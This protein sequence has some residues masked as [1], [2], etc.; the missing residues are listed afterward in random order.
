MRYET[1]YKLIESKVFDKLSI[2]ELL[3]QF[4]V[5]HDVFRRWI[6]RQRLELYDATEG[7]IEEIHNL[8]LS[9]SEA[10]TKYALTSRDVHRI[11][12]VGQPKQAKISKKE[13]AQYH[14]KGY[15]SEEIASILEC[16]PTRINQIK[17]ELNIHTTRKKRRVLSD[18]DRKAIKE[19]AKSKSQ[20]DVAIEFNVSAQT[21]SNIV[22][23]R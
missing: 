20:K 18:Q 8:A 9:P 21:V 1:L 4:Q 15:S 10:R 16:T 17:R 19:A 3:I 11:Y 23:G 14:E 12:Y 22:N 5:E 6:R 13:V 7:L 2:D